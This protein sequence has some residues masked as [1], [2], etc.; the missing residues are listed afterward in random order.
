MEPVRYFEGRGR[1]IGA[2]NSNNYN[3]DDEEDE[4]GVEQREGQTENGN[5]ERGT[6]SQE[7]KRKRKRIQ[8]QGGYNVADF[9]LDIAS[10]Y[11]PL[12]ELGEDQSRDQDRLSPS[13]SNS[14]EIKSSSL[15]SREKLEALTDPAKRS[16]R[17]AKS[18]RRT[19]KRTR[20]WFNFA[21]LLKRQTYP[22]TFLTQFEVLAWRE[23][24]ILCRYVYFFGVCQ[25]K[26][27]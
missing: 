22:T 3:D 20:S 5:G 13:S 12:F 24:K 7:Q 1:D 10:E 21:P 8:I 2:I 18:K 26:S 15:A 6:F 16:R 4:G 27:F 14:K 11:V 25:M 17:Q 9:L 19:L 23:W